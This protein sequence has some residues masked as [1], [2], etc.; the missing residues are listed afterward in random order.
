MHGRLEPDRDTPRRG[1][2]RSKCVARGCDESVSPCVTKVCRSVS[3]SCPSGA[4][5]H[6]VVT[7]RHSLD[8]HAKVP[9]RKPQPAQRTQ[10]A[11]TVASTDFVLLAFVRGHGLQVGCYTSRAVHFQTAAHWRKR[12]ASVTVKFS[13]DLAV[14]VAWCTAARVPTASFP[15]DQPFSVAEFTRAAR[16]LGFW[17]YGGK[18]HLPGR[19]KVPGP[20]T[21]IAGM[22]FAPADEAVFQ[23]LPALLRAP[24]GGSKRAFPSARKLVASLDANT[25][26]ITKAKAKLLYAPTVAQVTVPTA[27]YIVGESSTRKR[28]LFATR[29]VDGKR[30]TESFQ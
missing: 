13:T 27:V 2:G 17:D 11:G 15:Y 23:T 1:W 19:D 10:Q 8:T 9:V 6:E 5:R 14:D 18:N 25:K 24:P 21:I 26:F 4:R 7:C 22:E 3:R 29:G 20:A 16:Q 28:L 12:A 30:R